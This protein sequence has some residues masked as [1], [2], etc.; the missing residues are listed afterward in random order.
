MACFVFRRAGAKNSPEVKRFDNYALFQYEARGQNT[1][2][3]TREQCETSI[4]FF[5]SSSYPYQFP[6]LVLLPPGQPSVL[7]KIYLGN[8]I[9]IQLKSLLIILSTFF[10]PAKNTVT[11]SQQ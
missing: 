10:C 9:Y 4:F 6:G 11:N 8:R 7:L 1:I 5:H 2:Q 3:P